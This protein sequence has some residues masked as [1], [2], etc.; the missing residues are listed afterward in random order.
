MIFTEWTQ[1]T[2]RFYWNVRIIGSQ[3]ELARVYA[4]SDALGAEALAWYTSEVLGPNR[5]RWDWSFTDVI[6]EL[7]KRFMRQATVQLAT[8]RLENTQYKASSGVTELY[9]DLSMQTKWLNTPETTGSVGA[10]RG[11]EQLDYNDEQD[12]GRG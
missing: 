11:N 12:D 3:Q 1:N 6:L 4:I 2:C 5:T 7:H 8:A 9:T 10:S